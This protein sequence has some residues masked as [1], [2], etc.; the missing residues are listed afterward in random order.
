MGGTVSRLAGADRGSTELTPRQ[1]EVLRLLGQGHTMK[2]VAAAL[3]V[4]PR[5]VALHKYRIMEVLG[6]RTNAVLVQHAVAEGLT[7]T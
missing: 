1:I 5:T 2:E 3:G 4:S 6:I 7:T